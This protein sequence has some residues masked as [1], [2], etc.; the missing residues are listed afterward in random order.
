[1]TFGPWITTSPRSPAG[2]CVPSRVHDA[3][4]HVGAGPDRSRLACAGRQRIRRHLVRGLGHAVRLEHRRAERR[5]E[6]VHHL[7][8]QRRAARA[9]E[10]QLLGAGGLRRVRLRRAPSSSWWIVGTAEYHV[11][12]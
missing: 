8:R 7:R 11:T 9:D 1:M 5:F 2:R 4:L 3:D 10:A 12:P 6:I